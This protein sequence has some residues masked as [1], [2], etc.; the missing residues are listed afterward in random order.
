MKIYEDYL[1]ID[2]KNCVCIWTTRWSTR[3][4]A[5]TCESERNVQ[6]GHVHK[7]MQCNMM[8]VDGTNASDSLQHDEKKDCASSGACGGRG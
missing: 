3:K 1:H 2:K 8:R 4:N 5:M 7:S 6:I